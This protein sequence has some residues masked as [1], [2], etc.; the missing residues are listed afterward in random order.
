MIKIIFLFQAMY[1]MRLL[2]PSGIWRLMTAIR[3][4]GMNIMA[5][6]S[7]SEQNYGGSGA[8]VCERETMT[9]KQLLSE[10]VRLSG[11]L[12]DRFQLAP[13]MKVGLAGRNGTAFVQAVFAVS[14]TGADLY[15]L[16][17]ELRSG[18]LERLVE[19]NALDLLLYEGDP[20]LD[21]DYAYKAD[22]RV[23][24]LTELLQ[25]S[26]RMKEQTLLPKAASGRIMLL[27]GGTTGKSKGVAH[28][29]SLLHYLPPLTAL[30]KRL[31]LLR[32][33]SVYI[34]T[35][36]A[37]GYGIAHL[38]MFV[39]LG[40]KIVLSPRFE[41]GDTCRL[42]REHRM[43]AA[44]VVPSMLQR[45]MRH[46][47][48]SLRSLRCIASGG[49]ELSPSLAAETMDCLG[50]VLYNLY[51]TTEGGLATIATP[52]DLREAAGT[53]GR[54]M[55]G[56]PLQV[57]NDDGTIA[58]AG[59]IGRLCIRGKRR[60]WGRT[61]WIE[62][63]DLGRREP[64]GLYVLCGRMD[65]MIVSGGYNVYPVEIEQMLTQHPGVEGAAAIGVADERF[66]Q[67][68]IAF[69][70]PARRADLTEAELLDWLRPRVTR[71]QLPREIVFLEELPYTPLGKLDKK[72]LK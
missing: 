26:E 5:L 17:A 12:Q 38:L 30:L 69:V 50:D 33:R 9:Y 62:T 41:A 72:L 36:I 7:L 71:Y 45:M 13:G 32:C 23:V 29:P 35:P 42:I 22:F 64:N 58:A 15:L 1:R 25:T 11:V 31:P 10:S 6:L 4:C 39:A 49:A 63:G 66:G 37:H 57:L 19:D 43:E 40:Y 47:S 21:P 65:D 55:P 60:L 34:A 61:V 18:Q 16:S 27:T 20:V 28:R 14:S 70:Q 3:R 24:G 56:V 68:L 2:T 54:A 53:I 67:R 8:I 46:D 48:Q 52:Q 59:T 44:T 51:G